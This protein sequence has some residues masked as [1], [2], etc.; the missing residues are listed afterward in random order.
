TAH[1]EHV[2]L[3]YDA[4]VPQAVYAAGRLD[5]AL[6]DRGY[7]VGREP[8]GSDYRI[9]LRIDNASLGK[10][11]FAMVPAGRAITISG[12]DGAGLVYGSLALVEALAN[13]TALG[14]IQAVQAAPRFPFRGIKHNLPW[15]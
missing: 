2:H 4:S 10:E 3:R 6:S 13:G 7:A 9:E 12:G 8:A 5:R 15:D 14:A 1:A 11:A